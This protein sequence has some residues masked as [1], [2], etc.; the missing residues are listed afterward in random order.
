MTRRWLERWAVPMMV[1][2]VAAL[3]SVACIGLGCE[4]DAVRPIRSAAPEERGLAED[5]RCG[6]RS[7]AG[8]VS[9]E[10]DDDDRRSARGAMF[11]DGIGDASGA[12]GTNDAG[13]ATKEKSMADAAEF[14]MIGLISVDGDDPNATAAPWLPEGN[15]VVQSDAGAASRDAGARR[16]SPPTLREGAVSV[17]GR[18]PQEVIVRIVRQNFGR[19]RLCYETGL[20]ANPALA[21]RVAVKFVIDRSGSVSLTADGGSDLPDQGVVNCVL[22]AFG[23]LKFHPPEGGMVTVVYP[24]LLSPGR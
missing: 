9:A 17:N 11:G 5:Y 18:L 4:P 16:V 10:D 1:L 15:P 6:P 23:G 2:R 14:G 24:I 3:F 13:A 7:D 22:R 19:V 12:G 20:R 8:V 21:G